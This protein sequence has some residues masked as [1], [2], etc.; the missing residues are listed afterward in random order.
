MLKMKKTSYIVVNVKQFNIM[1]SLQ[2]LPL[3]LIIPIALLSCK[4]KD[5]NGNVIVGGSELTSLSEGSQTFTGNLSEGKIISD[6]SWAW[7]SSMACFVETAKNQYKGN[8]VFYQIDI[9]DHTTIDI[10]L[11]PTNS[12]DQI[13]LYGY[14]K[15]AGDKTIPPNISSCVSCEADPSNSNGATT[16]DRHIYLN[17]VN[18]PYSIIFGVAGAE[19]VTSG[20]YTVEIVVQ[21]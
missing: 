15:G 6:L 1:K 19:G 13:A 21:S 16:G 3:L 14:S 2:L 4:K 7:N 8:H 20:A 10:Y 5:E 17:A 9:P 18:N 11:T 12:N